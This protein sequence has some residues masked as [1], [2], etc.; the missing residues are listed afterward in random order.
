MR[1]VILGVITMTH[2]L[3]IWATVDHII[4]LARK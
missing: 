1:L 2:G 4:W 3:L